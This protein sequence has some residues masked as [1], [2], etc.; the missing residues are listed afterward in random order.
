MISSLTR[1]SEAVDPEED[2][3]EMIFYR[4]VSASGKDP[5]VVRLGPVHF[6][7][8]FPGPKRIK[9][10]AGFTLTLARMRLC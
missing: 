3:A 2:S 5:K 6:G 8:Y 10:V 4:I 9:G 1:L 7:T